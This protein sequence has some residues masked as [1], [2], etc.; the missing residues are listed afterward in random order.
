MGKDYCHSS[1]TVSRTMGRKKRNRLYVAPFCY[2]CEKEC[3]DEKVL[4]QHQKARHFKCLECNKKLDTATGLVVHMIQVHKIN[5][6]KVPHGMEGV[7]LELIQQK[8]QEQADKKGIKVQKS[9][10]TVSAGQFGIP[11][12]QQPPN[13]NYSQ[14]PVLDFTNPPPMTFGMMA[15]NQP[16]IMPMPGGGPMSMPFHGGDLSSVG[17]G[18]LHTALE[19]IKLAPAP[20][21]GDLIYVVENLSPDERRFMDLQRTLV[22]SS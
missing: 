10:H 16:T 7:P 12:Y 17:H 8:Q 18:G 19:S 20:P 15:H 6:S 11:Q 1:S 3:P 21:T 4:V 2:Y 22:R 5:I 9:S 14:R 13:L